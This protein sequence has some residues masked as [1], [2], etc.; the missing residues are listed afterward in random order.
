MLCI[1]ECTP[2]RMEF[3][4]GRYYSI[5]VF[6]NPKT[7]FDSLTNFLTLDQSEEFMKGQHREETIY[8]RVDID[9]SFN[10]IENQ[11][12]SQMVKDWQRVVETLFGGFIFYEVNRNTLWNGRVTG[13]WPAG[14]LG[15]RCEVL[16]CWHVTHWR[17]C[18]CTSFPSVGHQY[19]SRMLS[20]VTLKVRWPPDAGESWHSCEYQLSQTGRDDKLIT[21]RA[22]FTQIPLEVR[23]ELRFL[24]QEKLTHAVGVFSG[25]Y[26]DRWIC[27]GWKKNE[28]LPK[29]F[30][31]QS[32]DG[33]W[34]YK[35]KNWDGACK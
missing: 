22:T 11:K 19:L 2:S 15:D 9:L 31:L 20:N 14:S 30:S 23:T 3:P 29:F 28:I 10:R 8:E 4:W 6:L 24:F 17:Q 12:P 16:R 26:G 5:R 18:A 25:R 33:F 34:N 27:G 1:V 35:R 13:V 7:D 21:Q 32:D